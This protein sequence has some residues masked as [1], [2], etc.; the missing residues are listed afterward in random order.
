MLPVS[1]LPVSTACSQRGTV[2]FIHKKKKENERTNE[3]K[4]HERKEKKDEKA[5]GR[6]PTLTGK[7]LPPASIKFGGWK[8]KERTSKKIIKDRKERTSRAAFTPD[9]YT[10][11][12][13]EKI[14]LIHTLIA[15]P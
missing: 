7:T 6:Q 12:I 9:V 8:E 15:R 2:S 5:A 3:R 1:L 4:N 14:L 13:F 11:Y 10:Q